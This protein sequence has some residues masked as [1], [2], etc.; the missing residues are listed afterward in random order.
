MV[1]ELG[2]EL[3]IDYRSDDFVPAVLDATGGFGVDLVFDGV[4]GEVTER[5][6]HCLARDGRHMIIGFAGGIEAEDRAGVLP[7][8]LCFGQFSTGGVLLSYS[9]DPLA[10]RR[11]GPINQTPRSVGDDVHRHLIELLG[12]GA[13]HTVIGR[14]A[15]HTELP[16]ALDEMERRETVG[17]TVITWPVLN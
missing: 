11:R 17:R 10:A 7:R 9:R 5:S 15:P 13:I 6:L 3:V 8:L 12:A 1:T 4:G 16:A 14:V 2:A